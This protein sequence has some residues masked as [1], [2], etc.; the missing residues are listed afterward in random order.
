MKVSIC[1]PTYNRV[2]LIKKIIESV[3]S[4][5]FTDFELIITD[6]ASTDSTKKIVESIEDQRIRYIR[7]ASNL[8]MA[9]NW[10]SGLSQAR[11]EYIKVLMDDDALYPECLEQQVKVLDADSS[12]GVVCCDYNTINGAGNVIQSKTFNSESFRIFS[13]STKE[14]GHDFIAQYLLGKRRVGLPSSILFRR[15]V[16]KKVG[17]FDENI[18]CPADIDLWIRIA[19]ISNFYYLDKKLLAMRYHEGNLSKQLQLGPLG[20]R[21]KYNLILKALKSSQNN[22]RVQQNRN[23]ILCRTAMM[24]AYKFH[25]TNDGTIRAQMLNDIRQLNLS[26]L[27][28]LKVMVAIRRITI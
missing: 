3:L 15:S 5:T 26:R 9:K 4:Q 1:I 16:Q 11:G 28:K 7:H 19:S 14:A 20:Y 23:A 27:C 25:T 13:H 22:H 12:V 10:N 24:I 8:G 17:A 2:N 6:D 18:G 21:D